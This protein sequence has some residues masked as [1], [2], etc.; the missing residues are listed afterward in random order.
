MQRIF[1]ATVSTSYFFR[2]LPELKDFVNEHKP[3]LEKQKAPLLTSREDYE[4][5]ISTSGPNL[6]TF[7]Q[8]SCGHCKKLAPVIDEMA[9]QFSISDD[10]NIAKLD[11]TQEDLEPICQQEEVKSYPTLAL[12][13]NGNRKETYPDKQSSRTLHK[14]MHFVHK[15]RGIEKEEL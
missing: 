4:T 10:V 1:F 8:P 14:L 15:H 2:V 3:K 6:V 5:F 7:F 13:K 12:Y 9:T 11:C